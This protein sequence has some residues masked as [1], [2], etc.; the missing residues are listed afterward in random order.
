MQRTVKL[1]C[2]KWCIR[3]AKKSKQGS[4]QA[5]LFDFGM[6]L[7]QLNAKDEVKV[8]GM[9]YVFGEKSLHIGKKK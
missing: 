6:I 2:I 8:S 4:Q 7:K 5:A 9:V 3:Q 1:Q